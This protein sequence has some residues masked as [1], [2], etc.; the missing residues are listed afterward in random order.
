YS[1]N[2]ENNAVY[3]AHT[4]VLDDLM[5]KFPTMLLSTSGPDVG[6]PVGQMGNSEVGHVNIGAGRIVY[7]DYTRIEKAIENG[8]FFTNPILTH[9]V[10]QAVAQQKAVHI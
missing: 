9:T 4:P 10:D 5:Q 8:D 6:L 7:Q 2:T 3:T 1:E